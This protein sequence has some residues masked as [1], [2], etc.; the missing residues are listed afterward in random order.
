MAVHRCV[1]DCSVDFTSQ[2]CSV[3]SLRLTMTLILPTVV[4]LSFTVPKIYELNK[5]EID[6][7]AHT[8]YKK[9]RQLLIDK[10]G[11]APSITH[12]LM[13][14]ASVDPTF[15]AIAHR[16]CVMRA[17]GCKCSLSCSKRRRR[18]CTISM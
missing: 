13:Q 3:I 16:V 4:L 1:A 9:V 7:A 2:R 17:A 5:H 6:N 12:Q 18:S 10:L 8:G 15:W 11:A 14:A